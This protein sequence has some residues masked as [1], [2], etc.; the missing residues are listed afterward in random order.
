MSEGPQRAGTATQAGR[1][2]AGRVGNGTLEYVVPVADGKYRLGALTADNLDAKTIRV[3]DAAKPGVLVIRMPS[4]YV[5]LGGEMS[6]KPV[7]GAGGSIAVSFS[8]N[9]G[10]D[11][12]PLA[13][14]DVAG[15]QKIDLKKYIF[16]RYDYRVK[17]E[18]TGAGTGLD[19]LAFT[20]DIQH[21]QAPLP[22]IVEGDNKIAFAA[23]PQEGTITIEGNTDPE[24]VAGGKQLAYT[25]FHPTLSGM[26]KQNLRVGESG[27]GEV[28]FPVTAPGDITRI[29]MSL[30]WRARDARDNLEI[31]ASFD[32]GASWKSIQ[33][34]GQGQPA[35][36][37]Y[38]TFSGVP[39]AARDAQIKI[40]GSKRNTVCI[41][42][43]RIDVDYKEPNGGFAPVKVTY[44][45][46]EAG[47]EKREEHICA[48]P[49]DAWTI[50]CARALWPGATAWNSQSSCAAN[51]SSCCAY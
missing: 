50:K 19:A 34:L 16:R 22:I 14:I 41:F 27:K 10:L 13:K 6:F 46:T 32:K 5:Y 18:C 47:Q 45:W 21:S 15:E 51:K 17:F 44:V 7:S 9:N 23:G 42:D 30:H 8:D 40:V 25:D 37:A 12:R 43:M 29:R 28:I 48:T 38:F 1:S 3:A 24:A 39:A 33:K 31:F 49:Q 11:F 4:S 26:D 35:N 36:G 2:G 20:H